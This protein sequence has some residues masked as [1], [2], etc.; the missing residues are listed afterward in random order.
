MVSHHRFD[1]S[2]A[3]AR[4]GVLVNIILVLI[5]GWAGIISGSVA[6]LA[7]ALHSASDA[8][9]SAVV[10]VGIRIARRPA[11]D[12]HPY[13]HGKAESIAGKIVS[14]LVILAGLNVGYVSVRSLF[15]P[16]LSA[17]GLMALFAA[18]LSIVIKEML[19]RYTY[20]IGREQSCRA[21]VAS[22]YDH[23]SDAISSVAALIGIAGAR[24]GAALSD[25]RLFYLDPL[26]G[27]LVSAFIV[28]LGWKLAW[29]AAGELMDR[30]V[31][32]SLLTD[33]AALAQAVDGVLEVH[34]IKVRVAGPYYMVDMKIGVDGLTTVEEGH[35]VARRVKEHLLCEKDRVTE[36]LIHVNPCQTKKGLA[37]K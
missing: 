9:V 3:G 27:V 28:R 19:F 12:E 7:D 23:R 29:E 17:P 13:G 11:D 26:A 32:A 6:M 20:R 24:V 18:L 14:I 15:Y 31:E 22:A 36:V 16:A 5:K 10:W 33:L 30:R 21:L 35:A 37:D 25:P 4:T 34:D 1:S 8:V 2:L